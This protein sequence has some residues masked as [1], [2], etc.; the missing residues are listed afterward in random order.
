MNDIEIIN[1][2]I[3]NYKPKK[4]YLASLGDF[5]ATMQKVDNTMSDPQWNIKPRLVKCPDC[6]KEKITDIAGPRCDVLW[7]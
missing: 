2:L 5:M 3:K 6:E 4:G 1:Y 7:W